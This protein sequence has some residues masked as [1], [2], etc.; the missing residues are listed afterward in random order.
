MSSIAYLISSPLYCQSI[1]LTPTVAMFI[2][3][4]GR[5]VKELH[6]LVLPRLP[7]PTTNSLIL[8]YRESSEKAICALYCDSTIFRQALPNTLT[9]TLTF[10]NTLGY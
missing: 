5:R 3:S 7:S 2:L 9:Y 1:L 10:T 8:D 6:R 4:L